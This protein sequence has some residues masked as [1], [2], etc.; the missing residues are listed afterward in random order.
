MIILFKGGELQNHVTH[1]LETI[2]IQLY[3][4]QC[5]RTKSSTLRAI[6]NLATHNAKTV[7]S[8]LLGQP[9]PYDA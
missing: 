8:I 5:H 4:I 7:C 9:L 2:L 1:I 3:K 6:L